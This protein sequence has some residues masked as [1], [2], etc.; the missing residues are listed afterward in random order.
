M[1]GQ[2]TLIWPDGDK[3]VGEFKNDKPDGKGTYTYGSGH[4]Y[5]GKFKGGHKHGQGTMK[6]PDGRVEK[7][8]WEFDELIESQQ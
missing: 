4:K 8:I 7:G 2:G 6:Y 5:I 1:H 3:Y